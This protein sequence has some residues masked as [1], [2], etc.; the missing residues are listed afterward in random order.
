MTLLR[1]NWFG[2]K[3]HKLYTTA[4]I[5]LKDSNSIWHNKE[6]TWN[7]M[8]RRDIYCKT[9]GMLYF[10]YAASI[11][12]NE[13]KKKQLFLSASSSPDVIL[14]LHCQNC[15]A[16]LKTK[17]HLIECLHLNV[18]TVQK[19]IVHRIS[20][21]ISFVILQPSNKNWAEMT[22]LIEIIWEKTNTYNWVIKIF[23]RVR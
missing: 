23:L 15:H 2:C 7:F 13:R 22:K 1:Y 9:N 6:V 5:R 12:K 20:I 14:T 10:L 8:T 19:L 17:V 18:S 4:T 16:V 21:S 3:L 11:V